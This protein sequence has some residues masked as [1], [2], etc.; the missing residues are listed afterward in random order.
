MLELILGNLNG[1]T[2]TF[3]ASPYFQVGVAD[4]NV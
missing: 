4:T 2:K 1:I 3:A